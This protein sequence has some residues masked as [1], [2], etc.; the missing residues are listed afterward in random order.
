MRSHWRRFCCRPRRVINSLRGRCRGSWFLRQRQRWIPKQ[1]HRRSSM[2]LFHINIFAFRK[3]LVHIVV[4]VRVIVAQLSR[5]VAS[6]HLHCVSPDPD[7]SCH[8]A[9]RYTWRALAMAVD[10]H[11]LPIMM[12]SYGLS[13]GTVLWISQTITRHLHI[14]HTVGGAPDPW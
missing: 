12:L 7:P 9:V 13:S 2:G 11:V 5:T 6:A 1:V 10:G 4:L 8:A 3:R 14:R